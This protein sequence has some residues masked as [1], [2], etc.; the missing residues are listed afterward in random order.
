M[1]KFDRIE[2]RLSIGEYR[3]VLLVLIGDPFLSWQS[4]NS[5]LFRDGATIPIVTV[6]LNLQ[7]AI[8][9]PILEVPAS[10]EISR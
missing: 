2:Y 6:P 9:G 1:S 7:F 5:R 8:T 4:A 10:E 3:G